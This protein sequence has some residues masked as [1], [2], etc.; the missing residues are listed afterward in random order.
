MR[1][2]R[3]H[4]YKGR[5]KLEEA[6]S[7][8]RTG[9]ESMTWMRTRQFLD[10]DRS[11]RKLSD[12]LQCLSCASYVT[13]P[14]Q[15]GFGET[16]LVLLSSHDWAQACVGLNTNLRHDAILRQCAFVCR[17]FC[18]NMCSC[19]QLLNKR[20]ACK[21]PTMLHKGQCVSSIVHSSKTKPM[22]NILDAIFTLCDGLSMFACVPFHACAFVLRTVCSIYFHI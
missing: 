2:P 21:G 20:N 4:T 14:L 19:K 10:R 22:R 3:P 12:H 8:S 15:P 6:L 7:G 5:L 17:S 9:T 18:D 1:C 11:M 13:V 16:S